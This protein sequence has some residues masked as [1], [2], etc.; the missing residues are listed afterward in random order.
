MVIRSHE[1]ENLF[2]LISLLFIFKMLVGGENVFMTNPHI[3]ICTHNTNY[4]L[5]LQKLWSNISGLELWCLMPLS[6][7]FQ[8]YLGSQLY[9][10]RKPNYP[11]KPTDLPQVT[12]QTWSHDVASST[13]RHEW[14][15]NSQRCFSFY[16]DVAVG[17]IG[18]RYLSSG[19][20]TTDLMQVND[21]L[22]S[23]NH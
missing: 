9:W 18:G 5:L 22:L 23:H 1:Y 11:K 2:F 8:L 15:S 10:W 20:K 7:I 14:D 21:K 16:Y 6:A 4:M 17:F 3:K 13:P 12:F 19:R